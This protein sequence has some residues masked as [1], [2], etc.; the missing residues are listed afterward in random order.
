MADQYPT[1]SVSAPSG[2]RLKNTGR[3]GS[4]RIGMD[5]NIGASPKRRLLEDACFARTLTT[6]GGRT[7]TLAVVADGIGGE[8]SG[9][10][11]ANLAVETIA[12]SVRESRGDDFPRI[13]EA[14]FGRANQAVFE[15]G[16]REEHKRG[17][18]STAAAA[19]VCRDRLYVASVGDSRAYLVRGGKAVQLTSDHTWGE[20][21]IRLGKLRPEEAARNPHLASLVRS[22]GAGPDVAVDLGLYWNAREDESAARARQGT[23]LKRGDHVVLCS[24]GL[25][26]ER[27]DG[28]GH[29]VEAAEFPEILS[30]NPP[31]Q[32]ARTLVSKA[33][34]RNADDN[35]SV[36]VLKK[37]GSGKNLL[38]L[39]LILAIFAVL[40]FTGATVGPSIPALLHSRSP[41]LPAGMIRVAE[42]IGDGLYMESGQLPIKLQPNVSLPIHAGGMLQTLE[43][44]L[45]FVLPDSSRV[46]LDRFSKIT[47]TQIADPH[48]GERNNV[49]ALEKG[50]LMI[51]YSPPAGFSS[52]IAAPGNLRAQVMGS[53]LGAAYDPAQS[54]LEADCLEGE[55]LVANAR[56]AIRLSAG[57]YSWATAAGIGFAGEARY[58]QW[59]GLGGRDTAWITP[60]LM[61]S[62]T[63][64]VLAAPT[65]KYV[66]VKTTEP[67]PPGP[68]PTA[69]PVLSPPDQPTTAPP[70]EAPPTLSPDDT[71]V[72]NIQT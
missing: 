71:P 41:T 33:M 34:G 15:E 72:P 6:A 38:R 11:A 68:N 42:S 36:I 60:T 17:M 21:M 40:I 53:I 23:I 32:A 70:T 5:Q 8:S 52:C 18:G 66:P 49:L 67:P 65:D 57:Q 61:P 55:C 62:A 30:R 46:H 29:F 39:G 4:I 59:V 58:E 28:R 56:D 69:T 45:E 10:R 25:I 35:V 13:L 47:L 24:D 22:I 9:E 51:V 43:G 44:T 37:P 12:E 2:R 26:K 27:P 31:L 16:Q 54:R 64:T 20:E 14:A 3:A 48:T 1:Q 19:L 63:F 50:R 7:V